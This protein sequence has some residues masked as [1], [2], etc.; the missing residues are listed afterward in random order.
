MTSGS[1]TPLSRPQIPNVSQR[2]SRAPSVV[3]QAASWQEIEAEEETILVQEM[4]LSVP[5]E[6]NQSR[7]SVPPAP[8][9]P[10][11][12]N[13]TIS[14]WGANMITFGRKPKGEDLLRSDGEGSRISAMELG[15]L[16]VP[17]AGASRFLPLR[18]TLVDTQSQRDLNG[19]DAEPALLSESEGFR[20]DVQATRD[21]LKQPT[22]FQNKPQIHDQIEQTIFNMEDSLFTE[23][24][25]K[26]AHQRIFL[27][28][29]YANQHS[30][31]TE[32]VQRMGLKALRFTKEDGDLA[33]FAGRQKLW[34]V[35]EKYQPEHIWM[36]PECGPWGGWN[37]L[38]KFKSVQLYDAIQAKQDSQLPHV[39][40]CA[41][42]CRFQVRN[43]RHFH[44]EQP[45]GSGLPHLKI[46]ESLRQETATARFDVSFWF[47]H[48]KDQQIPPQTKCVAHFFKTD[49][50]M[51]FMIRDA[52]INMTTKTLKG[53]F[54]STAIGKDSQAFAPLIAVVLP[55][56]WPETFATTITLM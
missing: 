5:V 13:L 31:L 25:N 12:G 51:R 54:P 14:E 6:L 39:R 10:L 55:T 41:K 30:P 28:E 46:F 47:A 33:T 9:L 56:W 27:L 1:S 52:Q 8:T 2:K 50:F 43:G 35:I 11:P 16:R 7:T 18:T 19:R 29:V 48:P 32:A 15:P 45:A 22:K 26:T 24:S 42:I 44:L 49:V 17:H 3:S 34:D 21:M 40:L 23:I 36:A 53:A 4:A 20:A 37:H 38:N